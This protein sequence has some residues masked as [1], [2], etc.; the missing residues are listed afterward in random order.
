ML[1]PDTLSTWVAY[2]GEIGWDDIPRY[3]LTAAF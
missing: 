1:E 2:A 3:G